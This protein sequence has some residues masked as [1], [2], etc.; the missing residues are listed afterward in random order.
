M[1]SLTASSSCGVEALL[2]PHHEVG[3]LRRRAAPGRAPRREEPGRAA[4]W[5]SLRQDLLDAGDRLVDRLLGADALGDDAVDRL[6]PDVL[7]P[8]Q[9]V[10]PVARDR[11]VVVVRGPRQRSASPRPCGAGRSGRA[12]TALRAASASAAA[13]ARRRSRD[14]ARASPRPRGSARTP[15]RSS[16][17]PPSLKTTAAIEPAFDRERLAIRA[18]RPFDRRGVLVVVLG[19]LALERVGDRERVVRR[20]HDRLRQERLVVVDSWSQVTESGGVQPLR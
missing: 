2:P 12:R 11:S 1:I 14:S 20:H 17:L 8:D 15:W 16:T 6:R 10:A 9:V 18:E 7:L 3:G 13:C 4:A 5:S 19:P